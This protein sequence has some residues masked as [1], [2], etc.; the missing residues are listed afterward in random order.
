MVRRG[1]CS[2]TIANHDETWLIRFDSKSYTHPWKDFA[3]KLRL[4]LHAC[5]RFFVK[6]F[7]CCHP[8]TANESESILLA[9]AVE[10]GGLRKSE[11]ILKH[12]R[13]KHAEP[14]TP[15][16]SSLD[17]YKSKPNQTDPVASQ[18]QTAR[19]GR[20]RVHGRFQSPTGWSPRGVA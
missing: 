9:L 17:G 4:V 6:F 20:W 15:K 8:N 13:N 5:I 18:T 11:S 3:N 19:W 2:I 12:M 16:R 14:E 1:Y 7:L 10:D